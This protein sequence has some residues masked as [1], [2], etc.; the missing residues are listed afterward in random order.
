MVEDCTTLGNVP[1]PHRPC[2]EAETCLHLPWGNVKALFVDRVRIL[3]RG[4]KKSWDLKVWKSS[5][6]RSDFI[7]DCFWVEE[8]PVKDSSENVPIT[9]G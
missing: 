3:E 8:P 4:H 7:V 5:V 9:P 1:V 6:G 2:H